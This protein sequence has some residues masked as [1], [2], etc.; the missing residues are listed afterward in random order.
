MDGMLDFETLS[1]GNRPVLLSVGLVMFDKQ[2]TLKEFSMNID[3]KSCQYLDMEIDANT[4]MWWLQQ[5]KEAQSA[6][7]LMSGSKA[8]FVFSE[9]EQF[10]KRNGITRIWGNGV[11]FDNVVAENY[12]KAL[13]LTMP[14]TFKGN[15][16]YRT[17]KSLFSDVK[18]V[19]S[20]THHSAVDDARDQANHLIQILNLKGV[21]LV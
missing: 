6:L 17:V 19:R 10:I 7:T 15:R 12:F 16:C 3:P 21:E 9:L 8:R 1:L 13:G 20:G 11:D 2:G 4:V 5:S 14:W 18:L